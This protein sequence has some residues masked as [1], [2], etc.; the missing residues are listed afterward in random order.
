[1][2]FGLLLSTKVPWIVSNEGILAM[3]DA[4]PPKSLNK[5]ISFDFL[6]PKG[7]NDEP[8]LGRL[9]LRGRAS[10]ETPHYVAI[11]SRGVVPHLSQ[12]MMRENTTTKG[13]YAALED[14]E[15]HK[16]FTS[17]L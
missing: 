11:S 6:G 13:M 8:R 14:C 5:L 15:C 17:Y 10:M 12:D 4:P 3:A 1:M 16:F 9:A 7:C 2:C